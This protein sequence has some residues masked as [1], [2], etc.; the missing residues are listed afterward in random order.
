MVETVIADY[1]GARQECRERLIRTPN[2]VA[3]FASAGLRTPLVICESAT[4]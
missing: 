4:T 2:Y 1:D 3:R